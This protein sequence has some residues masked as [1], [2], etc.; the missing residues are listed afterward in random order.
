MGKFPNV[1]HGCGE[2]IVLAR[3][4]A[5]WFE[6]VAGEL[7]SWHFGCRPKVAA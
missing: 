5:A 3:T 4:P 7:R 1:C 6:N 2:R